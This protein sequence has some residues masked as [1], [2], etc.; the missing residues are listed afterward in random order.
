MIKLKKFA[1]DLG[2]T[3]MTLWNWKKAGKI[4][5]HK[6][7]SMN[8]IDV[9][10]YNKF[11]GIKQVKEERVVIY[12]RV[13]STANK[14][15]LESQAQRLIDYCN[16][17]GYQVSKV[18]TEF[19][20]GLNDKRPKLEKLLKEQDF[21]KLVVEHKDRLTRFGF[22]FID[23]MLE[24][25]GINVEVVNNVET[26]KE[27]IVQDFVSV[28]TSFCARIY[29]QRRSKR[30]TEELVRELSANSEKSAK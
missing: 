19:G 5:F 30:K 25:N 8:Y 10:T 28:I 17:R 15:N 2:V 24:T 20:S 9:D 26:D 14:S 12:C 6:I 13:S 23:K 29:G 3:R 7:G 16:A 27:D 18:V 1:S 4:Q 11:L 21:T 22:N